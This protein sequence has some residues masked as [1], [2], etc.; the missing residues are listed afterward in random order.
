MEI[1]NLLSVASSDVFCNAKLKQYPDGFYEL[2]VCERPIFR[3]DGWEEEG[4]KKKKEPSAEGA[5]AERAK[6]RAR[7][8]LRDIALSTPFSFF[9]TFTLD[10]TKIERHDPAVI[11]KTLNRWLDN[12]VR[13]KGLC[14]IL[15][16]EYHKKGGIHFHGFINDVF[17]A[18]DS[19]HVDRLGHTIFNLPAWKFGFST[20]IRLYGDRFQAV[21]YVCKYI[22]KSDEKIGGRWYYSGG[23]LRRPEISFFN[24]PFSLDDDGGYQFTVCDIQTGFKLYRG[25]VEKN[26]SE[27]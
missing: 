24:T 25:R 4:A 2:L 17:S 10:Q 13:R 11:L 15:V 5:C 23:A 18:V 6:R 3:P 12:N 26:S 21:S 16:P 9:V 7:C 27:S 8:A 1:S 19:G 20:A 22:S 14:Y